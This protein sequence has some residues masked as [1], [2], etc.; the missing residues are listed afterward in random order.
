MEFDPEKSASNLRKHGISFEDAHGVL[1]DPLA[2][3]VLAK[4]RK[5]YEG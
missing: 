3:T 5:A 2:L 1:F 4:E